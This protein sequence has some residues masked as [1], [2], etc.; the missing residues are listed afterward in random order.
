MPWPATTP[1]RRRALRWAPLDYLVHRPRPR[2][3][4]HP[5]SPPVLVGR[6]RHPRRPCRSHHHADAGE[7]AIIRRLLP[8][9][10]EASSPTATS[11]TSLQTQR[12]VRPPA[13][14]QDRPRPA[15][16]AVGAAITRCSAQPRSRR[17]PR[18]TH[19]IPGTPPRSLAWLARW[20]PSLPMSCSAVC[21]RSTYPMQAVRHRRF[22]AQV[23]PFNA[24]SGF[25]AVDVRQ[26]NTDR[27]DVFRRTWGRCDGGP[28]PVN[29]QLVVRPGDEWSDRSSRH[30][31]HAYR[32]RGAS[33]RAEASDASVGGKA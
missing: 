22:Q 31:S 20:P 30:Q 19:R 16:P 5:T 29:G 28:M 32:R 2:Q 7:T 13:N 14:L 26:V 10:A 23:D 11:P 21:Q 27:A 3:H 17:R 12:A 4:R 33:V 24:A 1:P 8:R 25:T 9:S 15:W 18:R 6:H